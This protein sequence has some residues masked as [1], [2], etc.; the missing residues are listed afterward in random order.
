M[1]TDWDDAYNNRGYAS[2]VDEMVV[3]WRDSAAAYRDEM[4]SARRAEL[5]LEYGERERNRVDIFH[6]NADPVGVIIF[7]HGGY[8][9]AFDKSSWSHLAKVAVELGWVV[10]MPS[11]TLAPEVAIADITVEIGKAV[12]FVASRF[13]LSI[14]LTGHSA[15]GHLVSRMV[16]ADSPLSAST[17]KRIERVVSISGVHDLR[18]LI[19]T[20]MNDDFKMD[21]VAASTESPCLLAPI[22]NVKIDCVV[23]GDERPEFIR[24]NDLLANVWTGLSAITTS[25]HITGHNHFTVVEELAVEDSELVRILLQ[26]D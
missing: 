26:N 17:L 9:R 24:Q 7:V 14:R 6:P 19:K 3:N 16:C 22:T 20:A 12:D 11:Y 10:A 5:D 25:T 4:V 2:N 8:W 1:I 13:D 18:P 21:M 15:G 23:G